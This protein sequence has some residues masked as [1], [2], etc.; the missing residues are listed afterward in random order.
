MY[1]LG[2]AKLEFIGG[3]NWLK[4][5]FGMTNPPTKS[6]KELFTILKPPGGDKCRLPTLTRHL[7]ENIKERKG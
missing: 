5:V 7:E 1:F 3:V 6:L 4:F 2:F